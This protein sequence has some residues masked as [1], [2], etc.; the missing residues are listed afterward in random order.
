MEQVQTATSGMSQLTSYL[1]RDMFWR[2]FLMAVMVIGV[3]LF[4][5][6]FA[7]RVIGRDLQIPQTYDPNS[8]NGGQTTQTGNTNGG[9]TP[10]L[11]PEQWNIQQ[12][13]KIHEVAKA[14]CHKDRKTVYENFLALPNDSI[15]AIDAAYRLEFKTL[16]RNDVDWAFC[17]GF[18]A[19]KVIVKMKELGLDK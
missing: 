10:A 4:V 18:A 1:P 14:S 17:D 16:I 8:A 15:R 13:Q 7:K 19:A 3:G 12:S 2:Y 9:Y 6:W 11:T 5:W